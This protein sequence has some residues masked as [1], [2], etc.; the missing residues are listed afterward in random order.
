MSDTQIHSTYCKHPLT[1]LNKGY[2][3]PTR[4]PFPINC[5]QVEL[6]VGECKPLAGGDWSVGATGGG[7]DVVTALICVV[8]SEALRMYPAN[9]AARGERHT[10]KKVSPDEPLIAAALVVPSAAAAAAG[11]YARPLFS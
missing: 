1:P 2:T 7:D 5:A 11:A 8:S 6:K 9:G 10:L 4:I 3:T